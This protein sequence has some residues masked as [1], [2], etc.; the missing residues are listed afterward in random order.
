MVIFYSLNYFHS[1]RTKNKLRSYEKDFCAVE[2]P[3]EQ[4]M[5][6]E[7]NHWLKSAKVPSIIYV[8]LESLIK[9]EDGCKNNP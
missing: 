8:N 2:V 5:T 4:N 3:S 6:L 9:Q 1:C 7:L